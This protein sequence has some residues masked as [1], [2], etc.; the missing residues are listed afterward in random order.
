M[1]EGR[2]YEGLHIP[3]L[4]YCLPGGVLQ[5][6]EAIDCQIDQVRLG[7]T[8]PEEEPVVVRDCRLERCHV[9]FASLWYVQFEDCL[10]EGMK[11]AIPYL[12]YGPMLKHVVVQGA[13]DSLYVLHPGRFDVD[14]QVIL[15]RREFYAGVDWALD[16]SRA[17]IGDCELSGVPGRLIRRDP[18][19]QV[20]V[21]RER[22]SAAPWQEVTEGVPQFFAIQGFLRSDMDSI[23][24]VAAGPLR[25][26][27]LSVFDRLRAA[28]IAE[29][30]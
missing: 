12:T 2:R 28:G 23:V 18:A 16:I 13:I 4:E 19:T 1:V 14:M 27:D 25:S 5:G 24:L 3:A 7:T 15:R 20:L 8:G 22:V 30:D 17:Q 6:F 9:R 10:V 21:T 29:P 11:G 26:Q